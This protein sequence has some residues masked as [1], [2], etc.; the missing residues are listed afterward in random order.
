VVDNPPPAKEETTRAAA[1]VAPPAAKH[2]EIRQQAIPGKPAPAASAPQKEIPAPVQPKAS[3]QPVKYSPAPEYAPAPQ[4]AERKTAGPKYFDAPDAAPKLTP[5][6]DADSKKTVG[7]EPVKNQHRIIF[8]DN[9]DPIKKPL[10]LT[11]EPSVEESEL[12]KWESSL[13]GPTSEPAPEVVAWQNP[14]AVNPVTAPKAQADQSGRGVFDMFKSE[15]LPKAQEPE[16]PTPDYLSKETRLTADVIKKGG[17]PRIKGDDAEPVKLVTE[18]HD[19]DDGSG[20]PVK[21]TLSTEEVLKNSGFA[22]MKET[23]WS[24]K[25]KTAEDE[26]PREGLRVKRPGLFGMV[27]DTLKAAGI[28]KDDR[29]KNMHETNYKNSRNKR[30]TE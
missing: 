4:R 22:A 8:G 20:L 28:L 6:I 16:Q 1:A 29:M 13:A 3:A 14:D 15:P 7:L 10:R 2:A 26:R 23:R 30:D 19:Y 21:R 25:N 24:P 17:L 11:E 27:S 9:P 12:R 18:E 5:P